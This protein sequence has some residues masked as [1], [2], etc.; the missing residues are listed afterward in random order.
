MEHDVAITIQLWAVTHL[1]EGL[2]DQFFLVHFFVSFL[3]SF[4]VFYKNL[5][6]SVED[7]LYQIFLRHS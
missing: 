6:H 5:P 1:F 4:F 7:R 2:Q 3:L